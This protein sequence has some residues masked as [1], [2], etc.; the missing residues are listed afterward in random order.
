MIYFYIFIWLFPSDV[1]YIQAQEADIFWEV[2]ELFF[3]ECPLRIVK[4]Q[5]LYMH[6]SAYIYMYFKK[7]SVISSSIVNLMV[8]LQ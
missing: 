4:Q 6:S 2:Q 3:H 1:L 5:F 8:R 7:Q